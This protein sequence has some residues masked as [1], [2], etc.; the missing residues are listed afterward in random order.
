MIK[1]QRSSVI[2]F[3]FPYVQSVLK[4]SPLELK[5]PVKNINMPGSLSLNT[6]PSLSESLYMFKA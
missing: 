3:F 1:L 4:M 5:F 6:K 2:A